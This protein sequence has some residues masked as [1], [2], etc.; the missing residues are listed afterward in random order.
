MGQAV[1]MGGGGPGGPSPEDE[2]LLSVVRQFE[3]GVTEGHL[4]TLVYAGQKAGLLPPEWDFEFQHMVP[5][6]EA[7]DLRIAMLVYNG[8]V[9]IRNNRLRAHRP[10]TSS[11]APGCLDKLTVLSYD[12]LKLLAAILHMEQDLQK[13]RQEA[14]KEA[15]TLFSVREDQAVR[16]L[17]ECGT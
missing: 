9:S 7:L 17:Q 6:C 2:F 14:M 1:P 10:G 16:I 11:L 4:H 8:D 13:T 5:F 3:T 15:V 12:A